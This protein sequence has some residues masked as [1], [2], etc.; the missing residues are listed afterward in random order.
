MNGYSDILQA[1]LALDP[2]EREEL[3]ITLFESFDEPLPA[4][5]AT[6]ELSAAWRAEIARR[7]AAY[8]R[9]ELQPVP[10]EQVREEVPSLASIDED[11]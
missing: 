1:A 10:W 7:S 2:L 6:P 3:A 4:G 5:E 8:K 9:G 11:T